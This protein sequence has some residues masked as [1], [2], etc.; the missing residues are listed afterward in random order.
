MVGGLQALEQEPHVARLLDLAE[1]V[2]G[3]VRS[4]GTHAAGV[5]IN[6]EPLTQL[7]PLERS[8]GNAN[9]I[10]TQ[11]EDKQLDKLGLLKFDF[12][13]LANLTILDQALRL[14]ERTRGERIRR[15]DIPLNDPRTF[16]LLGSAETTRM[17]QLESAGRRRYLRELK[18]DK[19]E[20]IIAM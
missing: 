3:L 17:F 15:E 5:V 12:L 1:K 14:I 2:E 11:Y 20:D 18:P 13:G 4:T 19:V 10:Q 7:V 6:R 8:K 16:A 9:A